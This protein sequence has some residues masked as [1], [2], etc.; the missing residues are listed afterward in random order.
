[1]RECI[2]VDE[3]DSP[4]NQAND[5]TQDTKGNLSSNVSL[6]TLLTLR[7]THS[8]SDHID[9][10]DDQGSEADAAKGVGHC[11]FE[12]TA[13][14]ATRHPTW[15][16]RTEKPRFIDPSDGGVQGNLD[17]V[18]DPVPGEAIED[19]Q[20]DNLSGRTAASATTSRTSRIRASLIGLVLDVHCR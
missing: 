16:A 14:R 13:R 5:A 9:N 2:A 6:L 8:M 3:L 18:C 11:S 10:G 7:D 12:G 15:F 4:V 20:T 17:P 19:D 1:M